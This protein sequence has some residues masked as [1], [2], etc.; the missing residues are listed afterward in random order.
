MAKG[1]LFGLKSPLFPRETSESP[2][3]H[4]TRTRIQVAI[5]KDHIDPTRFEAMWTASSDPVDLRFSVDS[6]AP[7]LTYE[8]ANHSLILYLSGAADRRPDTSKG[9][10]VAVPDLAGAQMI[11]SLVPGSLSRREVE[12]VPRLTEG[13][14]ALELRSFLLRFG[15][16]SIALRSGGKVEL[17]TSADGFPVWSYILPTKLEELGIRPA[18]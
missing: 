7:T 17:H 12:S 13:R 8:M 5:Y 2:A 15:D 3:R 9:T 1:I 10:I 14:Y 18:H 11:L 6:I 16:R 4:L